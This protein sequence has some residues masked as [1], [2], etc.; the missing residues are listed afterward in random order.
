MNHALIFSAQNTYVARNLGAHR[1]ANHLRDEDWDVE[2]I[3]YAGIIPYNYLLEITKSRITTNTVFVAF[4][5]T[6]GTWH[7]KEHVVQGFHDIIDWIKTNFP[8][9]KIIVGSQKVNS[10]PI[11]AHYYINGYGEN[12]I[13][14]LVKHLLGTGTEKLKYT[15][16]RDGKLIH[17]SDYPSIYMKKLFVKYEDR[18]FIHHNDQLGCKRLTDEA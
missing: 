9:V 15:L 4:S 17:G 13:M 6:W 8:R 12:A 18:D 5:D 16:Y 3:D 11:K 1:I 2:V 14:A 10:S 7:A